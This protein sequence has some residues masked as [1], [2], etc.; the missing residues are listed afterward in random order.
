MNQILA[1]LH[2]IALG[3]TV[4]VCDVAVR[5][6]SLAG[7][8]V[9]GERGLDSGE[10]TQAIEAAVVD[11]S[12]PDPA[13]IQVAAKQPLGKVV[14]A[15]IAMVRD[16]SRIQVVDQ[17]LAGGFERVVVKCSS[18]LGVTVGDHRAVATRVA[19]ALRKC[20]LIVVTEGAK[21]V[22]MAA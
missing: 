14:S 8:D 9:A 21:V 2:L 15:V 16:D 20:G 22:V 12:W 13:A 6:S 3:A 5:R 1:A 17:P 7:F 11:A 10:A 4:L 18:K 19:G